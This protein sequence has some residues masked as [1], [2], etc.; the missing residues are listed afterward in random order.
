MKCFKKKI[1]KLKDISFNND[2]MIFFYQMFLK[3]EKRH[4]SFIAKINDDKIV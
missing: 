2:E 1:Y 3:F 4:P